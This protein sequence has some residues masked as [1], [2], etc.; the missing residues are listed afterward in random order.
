MNITL[1]L[2]Y[3]SSIGMVL[4]GV[5]Y[6]LVVGFGI[7]QAGLQN[8]IIDPTLAVMEAITLLS[9]PLIVILM[10]AMYGVA[11]KERKVF[12]ILALSFAI[13][14]AGLT[15]SVH[16]YALTAGR[17]TDFT[18]LEWPS[19]L[20]AIELLAWDIFLGMALVCAALT[21]DDSKRFRRARWSLF[22]TGILCLIGG[23]G[24]FLGNMALQ[25]IGIVGYGIALPI[26]CIF[27][28][29]VFH[30]RGSEAP[31]HIVT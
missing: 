14:M 7:A 20:Y 16:F 19:A 22:A 8:P 13:I 18:T 5:L 2:G 9:A 1:R 21:F 24:P 12:G 17:Q 29:R 28:A 30:P 3:L 10:V 6:A 31:P 25:R 11:N 26:S 4:V 15:S 23:V 27:L